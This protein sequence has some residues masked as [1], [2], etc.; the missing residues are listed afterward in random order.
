[1]PSDEPT[2]CHGTSFPRLL[3]EGVS[4]RVDWELR[5]Y[6]VALL[7]P[8]AQ[9]AALQGSSMPAVPSPPGRGSD[10]HRVECLLVLPSLSPYPSSL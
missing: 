9:V 5:F 2:L 8:T 6:Q 3:G 1:M 10:V 7:T 4:R